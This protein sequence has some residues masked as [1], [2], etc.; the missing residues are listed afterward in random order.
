MWVDDRSLIQQ[1]K[2]TGLTSAT[3]LKTIDAD[4]TRQRIRVEYSDEGGDASLK[5]E[6]KTPGSTVW[7]VVPGTLLSPDYGLATRTIVEDSVVEQPGVDSEQVTD[8]ISAVTYEHPWLGLATESILDPD[9][10]ALKTATTYEAIGENYLRRLT[11]RMPATVEVGGSAAGREIVS[12][13]WDAVTPELICGVPA[14]SKQYGML[15]TI[16]SAT[17]EGS[18]AVVTEFVYDNWSR[19]VGTRRTGETDWTCTYFNADS[20]VELTEYAGFGGHDARPVSSAYGWDG[21]LTVSTVSDLQGTITSK[22]DF[23]G[24]IRESID[25]WATKSVVKEYDDFGRAIEVEVTLAGMPAK[26]FTSEFDADGKLEWV[27]LNGTELAN[28]EYGDLTQLLTD[29]TYANATQLASLTR[30]DTGATLGMT[31][32]FPEIMQAVGAEDAVT[33]ATTDFETGHDS[34]VASSGEATSTASHAGA[35]S[36]LLEQADQDPVKLSR[37]FSDLTVGDAYT[38]SAWVATV[39]ESPTVVDATIGVTGDGSSTPVALAAAVGSTLTWQQVQWSFAATATT[40]EVTIEGFASTEDASLLVDDIALVRN[41]IPPGT[42]VVQSGST[43]TDAVI[44]SQSG[45]IIQNTLTDGPTTEIW[46]YT[47]DAAGRLTKA[48]L[49]DGNPS[50]DSQHEL[51]YEFASSGSCGVN[52][53][54]GMNGNRTGYKDVHNGVTVVDIEYCYDWADR[55]TGSIAAVPGGNPVLGSNLSEAGGSIDYDDHGNTTVLADQTMTYD[56]SDRH[57][58]TRLSNGTTDPDDDTLIT[59]KRDATGRIIERR[60]NTLGDSLPE[61]VY[62]Y[63]VGGPLSA[64]LDG[65]GALIQSTVSLPGGVQVGITAADNSEVW[66]YPNL[67][68]DVILTA[69]A[70][71]W[72][73]T[74]APGQSPGR[75]SFDPFGQPIDPVTG[76]I[77]TPSA[78][79]SV[80]NNLPGEADH[81][82]VGQHQKLYEHQGSIATIEMGVRQYVAALGR[83]LSVDPVEGGVTNAYDYP[84]D[85]VNK[86]DLTGEMSADSY[87]TM[88]LRGSNPK[89]TPMAAKKSTLTCVRNSCNGG[90]GGYAPRAGKPMSFLEGLRAFRNIP[91]T[92]IGAVALQRDGAECNA[93]EGGRV[94]CTNAPI[95]GTITLGNAIYTTGSSLGSGVLAHELS[96]TD[97][98]AILGNDLYA[99]IWLQGLSVSILRGDY[100]PH[101]GGC[102]NVIEL[103]AATGGNYEHVCA[104]TRGASG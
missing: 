26:L 89:W 17:S 30:S 63:T 84:A 37:A 93:V 69:D 48:V 10:L 7:E 96:H 94:L 64:V 54:A 16:T 47:F 46:S 92:L 25:V 56:V 85:P 4:G 86:F 50:T 74:A 76:A 27:K 55:L 45:R 6:W 49:D 1:W 19:L 98:S 8:I 103:T 28:P 99:F 83:F 13:Y 35:A 41:A 78:D 53:A 3:A 23:L 33:V 67:H 72:R 91:L 95:D 73:G 18:P 100:P 36:A 44:R 58:S 38:V 80:A 5:L 79:D 70:D 68:G 77:G 75:Y 62:R 42:E 15:K 43:V 81:G 59:Y 39:D 2:E 102:F 90:P 60:T 88:K 71:G 87:E 31:W 101:G 34:W 22:V 11:K 97:Q 24:R 66:S 21:E 14:G 104:N 61:E 40:H 32:E 65:T 12:T 57:M 52:T 51:T 9:G 29:V 20:K 82:F